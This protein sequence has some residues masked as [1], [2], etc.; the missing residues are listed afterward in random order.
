M[1]LGVAL[2]VWTRSTDCWPL[3]RLDRKMEDREHQGPPASDADR[4]TSNVRELT[5]KG[6]KKVSSRWRGKKGTK[7]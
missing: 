1:G 6:M 5:C 4:L 2:T 7:S 3:Q